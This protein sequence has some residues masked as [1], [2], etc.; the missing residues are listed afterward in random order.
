MKGSGHNNQPFHYCGSNVSGFNSITGR[1]FS[2]RFHSAGNWLSFVAD[3]FT[4]RPF[5]PRNNSPSYPWVPKLAGVSGEPSHILLAPS[6]ETLCTIHLFNPLTLEIQ[7][8][9][10]GTEGVVSVVLQCNNYLPTFLQSRNIPT[11]KWPFQCISVS[12]DRSFMSLNDLTQKTF[13]INLSFI[14][15]K[16]GTS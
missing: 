12:S 6:A 13:L 9:K 15:A 5:I 3:L 10:T 14:S 11:H 7:V 4:R 16:P 8:G 2:L 1:L